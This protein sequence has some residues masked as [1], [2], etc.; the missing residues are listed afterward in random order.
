M[1]L[2][3]PHPGLTLR[4]YL[5]I[6]YPELPN[7]LHLTVRLSPLRLKL[8]LEREAEYLSGQAHHCQQRIISCAH[9]SEQN[10]QILPNNK[11][12]V[13]FRAG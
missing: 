12:N 7:K 4:L 6:C 11:H 3:C 13:Y 1:L 5:L 10:K 2:L 9:V 8:L